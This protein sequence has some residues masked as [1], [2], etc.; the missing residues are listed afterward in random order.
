MNALAVI[1]FSLCLFFLRDY[2]LLQMG[3]ARLL[4]V[5]LRFYAVVLLGSAFLVSGATSRLDEAQ[6]LLLFRAPRV[7]LPIVALYAVPVA[8][9][10]WIQRTD[11][12]HRAWLLATAPNPLLA[13]SIALLA[14][15]MFPSASVYAVMLGSGVL[16][17]VWIGL[18]AV[19]LERTA[20]MRMDVPD[21]D[22]SIRFAGFVNSIAL[23]LL[24]VE[25][26]I[27]K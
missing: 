1:T 17:L 11:R 18:I 6:L 27:A 26:L 21:L 3:P 19:W 25:F 9:C 4:S 22:F 15:V 23:L 20:G 7:V 2:F 13:F 12:H 10:L 5:R 8:I 16:A 24:P 14:R